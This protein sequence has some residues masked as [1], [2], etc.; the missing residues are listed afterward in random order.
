LEEDFD[1]WMSFQG[2]IMNLNVCTT[3]QHLHI[4]Q[5]DFVFYLF[6]T[7]TLMKN[8]LIANDLRKMLSYW[9]RINVTLPLNTCFRL[10][11]SSDLLTYSTYLSNVHVFLIHLFSTTWPCQPP[12]VIHYWTLHVHTIFISFLPLIQASNNS[13]HLQILDDSICN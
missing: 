13:Y 8:V 5:L 10:I 11:V 6:Y 1:N 2:I 3:V 12:L 7:K 9:R 4:N